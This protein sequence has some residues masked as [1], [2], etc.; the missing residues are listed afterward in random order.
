MCELSYVGFGIFV[1]GILMLIFYPNEQVRT[2]AYMPFFG[3]VLVMF[4]SIV[5]SDGNCTGFLF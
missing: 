2:F 5:G 3:G 4:V 1:L